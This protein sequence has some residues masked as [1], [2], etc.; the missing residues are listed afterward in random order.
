MVEDE[1]NKDKVTI[2]LKAAC[3][4]IFLTSNLMLMPIKTLEKS[5]KIFDDLKN[6]T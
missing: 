6:K 4:I 1:L 5:R 3:Y 2:E